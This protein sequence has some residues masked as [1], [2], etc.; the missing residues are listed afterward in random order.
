MRPGAKSA[1]TADPLTWDAF[2]ARGVDRIDA[3]AKAFLKVPKGE[4]SG[5]PFVL[6]PWQLE[7]VAAL[8]PMEEPRPRQALLSLP[9]GNGKTGL[10]A[11]LALYGL[12]ADEIDAP[13][14]LVVASSE[15]TAQHV[16]KA[17]R[18]MI[19]LNPE[20]QDRAHVYKDRIVTPLN[21]GEF[22]ALPATVAAL[23]GWDPT[24]MI[25]DE[26]HVVDRDVWEA[27]TSASGKRAESLTLAISTPSDSQE[28]VMWDLVKYGRKQADPAFVFREWAAPEGCAVDDE[29]AWQI[30]NPALGDFLSIDALRATQATT[31]EAAFRRYRLGQWAGSQDSWLP[32]GMWD[33]RKDDRTLQ[34]GERI[35][36]GF[37]GSASGDST[38]LIACTM[39]GFISP[40]NVWNKPESLGWRVPRAE[41]TQAVT[42]AFNTF[43]VVEL[44]CDPWGWR[45]EIEAWSK[46]HG[47]RRVVEYNTGFR[48]RMGPA[49]DRLY[50]AVMDHTMTHDGNKT[51]S[52]H[53]S[54]TVA[55]QTAI[56]AIVSKDKRNSP[57]KIDAAVA[58]IVAWDRAA[59]HNNTKK[60]RVV[61]F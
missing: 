46:T 43:D 1:I 18:R 30:A 28:S 12:F 50:A 34:P 27:V 19:E 31:R 58:A 13:Q 41:V 37:D 25:V 44:A 39:D 20:L 57:R 8:Y 9:R 5:T 26:L 42:D 40:I 36:L 38:A 45:S 14:V 56:G 17:A 54:Q 49:T 47:E 52:L 21:G 32:F 7:T 22:Y 61:S 51:L 15:Q 29:A 53:V 16:Y 2:P 55:V 48:N 6:R 23:Q 11:L 4:G 35:V 10:A 33:T 59:W 60:R 24:L 3:F